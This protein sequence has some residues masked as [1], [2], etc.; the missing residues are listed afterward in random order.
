VRAALAALLLLAAPAQAAT[1]QTAAAD[2]IFALYARGDYD[3]AA[4]V[5]EASHTAPGL[6]IAARAVLAD[7]VLRDEPC[8][9]CLEHAESLSRQAIAADPH[10]AFGHLWLAVALGYE[11]RIIGVVR[12]R[13]KD[14]PAQSRQALDAAIGDDPKNPYA[15]SALGGWHIEIVRGGGATLARFLYGAKESE[16]L[17]LFDRAARLAPGNVAVRYQIGL[18]LAGFDREKYHDRI[19]AEFKAAAAGTAQTAYEKKIQGRAV[20]LLGLLNAA[21]PDGFD[22]RVRKYQGFP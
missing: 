4:R 16:A 8:M 7:E 5:G 2:E 3:Q 12:A 13:L 6:A 20:E 18:S 21:N 9:P 15:I 19:I 1:M 22:T 11:A 17:E 10:Q 14:A